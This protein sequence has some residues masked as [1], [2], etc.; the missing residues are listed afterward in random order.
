MSV[1]DDVSIDF[2]GVE[3]V[4][5]RRQLAA[6]HSDGASPLRQGLVNQLPN[7]LGT[8]ATSFAHQIV[9]LGKQWT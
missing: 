2:V 9:N 3:S 8:I 4:Q 6:V 1:R 5:Q 7:H